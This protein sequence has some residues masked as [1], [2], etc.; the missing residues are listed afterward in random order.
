MYKVQGK[1]TEALLMHHEVLKIRLNTFGPDHMKVADT[2]FNIGD[3]YNKQGKYPEAL[4]MHQ[5]CLNIEEKIRGP[6]HPD[7][8]DT[9]NR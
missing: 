5:K 4:E 6:E 8:A 1:Y 3:V 2:Y 7:V 9:Y